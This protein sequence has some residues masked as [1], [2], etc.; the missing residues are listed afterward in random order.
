DDSRGSADLFETE[1]AEP[2]RQQVAAQGG[3]GEPRAQGR[4]DLV[5]SCEHQ[6][7]QGEPGDHLEQE[8]PADG[9][10]VLVAGQIKIKVY[11]GGGRQQPRPRDPERGPQPAAGPRRLCVFHSCHLCVSHNWSTVLVASRFSIRLALA[12]PPAWHAV[13]TGASAERG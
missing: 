13:S 8:Q 6:G 11:R 4:H 7:G 9:G 10:Y 12:R 2:Y 1:Q 3:H 5:A